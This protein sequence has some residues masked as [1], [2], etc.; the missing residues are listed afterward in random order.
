MKR[1]K[2]RD[3]VAPRTRV[4]VDLD[5]PFFILGESWSRGLYN[6]CAPVFYLLFTAPKGRNLIEDQVASKETWETGRY[7]N[8][9]VSFQRLSR[10][11]SVLTLELPLG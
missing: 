7:P 9:S 1:P 3:G 6:G 2:T 4:L 11:M 8:G 10:L 5:F